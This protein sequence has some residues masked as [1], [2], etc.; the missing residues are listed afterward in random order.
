MYSK[1]GNHESFSLM[2]TGILFNVI[3]QITF[4]APQVTGVILFYLY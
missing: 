4:V 2:I 1:L 3:C